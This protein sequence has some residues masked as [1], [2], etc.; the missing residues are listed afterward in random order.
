MGIHIFR[1]FLCIS[2]HVTFAIKKVYTARVYYLLH[3]L[4]IQDEALGS[5]SRLTSFRC[6]INRTFA[7][8]SFFFFFQL[9]NRTHIIIIVVIWQTLHLLLPA[10]KRVYRS[11]EE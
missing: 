1:C 3:L 10:I 8:G 9:D 11:P 2:I 5:R 4:R 7:A 6:Y